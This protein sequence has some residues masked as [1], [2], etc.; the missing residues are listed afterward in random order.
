ML[1]NMIY[2]IYLFKKKEQ[3]FF[4]IFSKL[5]CNSLNCIIKQKDKKFNKQAFS[6]NA[7][8]TL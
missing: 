7:S 8:I 6:C 4:I 3:I 1:K 5:L 2:E